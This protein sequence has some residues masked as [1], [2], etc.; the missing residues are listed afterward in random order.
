MS[1]SVTVVVNPPTS[2]SGELSPLLSERFNSTS[3]NI[4]HQYCPQIRQHL[5]LPS[6]AAVLILLWTAVIGIVY[7]AVIGCILLLFSVNSV[8]EKNV[9]TLASIPFAIFTLSMMFY[10]LSGFLADVCCGRFRTIMTS[11]IIVTI[12]IFLLFCTSLL[13]SLFYY[14][15]VSPGV[16]THSLLVG[17]RGLCF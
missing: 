9:S 16:L 13:L 8:R 12:S 6:K 7:H 2:S 17:I 10:P 5:C 4:Y 11:L 1:S 3:S 15:L 14:K